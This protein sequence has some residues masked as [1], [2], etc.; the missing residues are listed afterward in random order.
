MAKNDM[1]IDIDFV[2]HPKTKRLISKAG[3]E[4]FYCL[5]KL[6]SSVSKIYKKGYLKDCDETDIEELAGWTGEPG[7]LFKA[8]MDKR[9]CFLEK[10]DGELYVHDWKE[11]QP[12]IYFSD[13]RSEIARQNIRKRWTKKEEDEEEEIEEPELEL[14]SPDD[15]TEEK[16]LSNQQIVDLFKKTCPSL[17]KPSVTERRVKS[18]AAIRKAYSDEQ[19]VNAFELAEASDFLSGRSGDWKCTFDWLTIKGNMLKVLEGNYENKKGKKRFST[20]SGAKQTDPD[21]YNHF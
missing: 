6:F 18:L 12:W 13:E 9:I 5:I 1:R 15:K 4:G 17:P 19:I 10:V 8:L 7:V 20:E 14:E 3:F 16:R 21:D 2:D 11:H